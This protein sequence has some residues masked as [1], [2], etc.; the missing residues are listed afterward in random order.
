M[1]TKTTKIM[2]K[3]M[4]AKTPEIVLKVLTDEKDYQE[5]KKMLLVHYNFHIGTTDVCD[6]IQ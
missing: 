3:T 2:T 6:H 4:T 1:I 5:I